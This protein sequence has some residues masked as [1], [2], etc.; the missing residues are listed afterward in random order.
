MGETVQKIQAFSLSI[1]FMDKSRQGGGLRGERNWSVFDPVILTVRSAFR[2]PSTCDVTPPTAHTHV[3]LLGF[4]K[5]EG[6]AVK[7]P[8]WFGIIP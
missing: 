1:A 7:G 5:S 6:K 4:F 3:L 2:K 8:L